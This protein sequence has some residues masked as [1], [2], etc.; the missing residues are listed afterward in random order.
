MLSKA[1]IA[2]DRISKLNTHKIAYV[3]QM[4][5]APHTHV[6][7]DSCRLDP[8]VEGVALIEA[9]IYAPLFP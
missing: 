8:G 3:D 1:N 4:N 5:H 6:L 9:F 2:Y 7:Y